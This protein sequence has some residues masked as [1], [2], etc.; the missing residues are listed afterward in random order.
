MTSEQNKQLVRQLIEKVLT[1]GNTDSL[2]QHPGLHETIPTIERVIQNLSERSVSF[3]LQIAEGEWVAMRAV[4]RG[5]HTG[6]TFG[7]EATGNQVEYE[8]LIFNRV[9]D[10]VIVQQHSQADVMSIMEQVGA[11]LP[12]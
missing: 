6:N 2:R 5:T 9:V 10:G 12:E 4:F 3:P 7:A 11:T 1:S 8:V